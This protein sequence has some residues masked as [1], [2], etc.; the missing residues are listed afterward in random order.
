LPHP[1]A[2][3]YTNRN[4]DSDGNSNIYCNADTLGDPASADAKAAAHAVSSADA[5][6]E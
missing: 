6:S 5:V 3:G 2:D 1:D 4:G